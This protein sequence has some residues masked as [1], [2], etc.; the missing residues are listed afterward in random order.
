MQDKSSEQK[1]SLM[2]DGVAEE[3]KVSVSINKE[4]QAY[5]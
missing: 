2:K 4:S 5:N 1:Y 3:S